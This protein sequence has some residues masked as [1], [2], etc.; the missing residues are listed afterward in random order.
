MGQW[1][2]VLDTYLT[3]YITRYDYNSYL[4][5][6]SLAVVVAFND[7]IVELFFIIPKQ[8]EL[9]LLAT[10]VLVNWFQIMSGF[11]VSRLFLGFS[12]VVRH[13]WI[14]V[15]NQLPESSRL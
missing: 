1:K 3:L 12:L 11:Y 7:D 13:L 2:Q 14:V 6:T 8:K 9:Q 4:S 5:G 10:V 15:S